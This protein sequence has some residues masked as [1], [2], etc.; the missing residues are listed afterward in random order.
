MGRYKKNVKIL[1]AIDEME[2]LFA[3]YDYSNRKLLG[4]HTFCKNTV[5]LSYILRKSTLFNN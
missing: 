5:F 1:K 4:M 3:N 2:T